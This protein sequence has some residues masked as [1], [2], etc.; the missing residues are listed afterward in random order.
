MGEDLSSTT[1]LPPSLIHMISSLHW[2]PHY[3]RKIVMGHSSQDYNKDYISDRKQ[4]SRKDTGNSGVNRN[5]LP[6]KPWIL[7]LTSGWA[8]F[9][10]GVMGFVRCNFCVGTQGLYPWSQASSLLQRPGNAN[11]KPVHGGSQRKVDGQRDES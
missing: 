4:N 9:P 11:S 8:L 10:L 3:E 7:L 6:D 5:S 2:V 1:Y